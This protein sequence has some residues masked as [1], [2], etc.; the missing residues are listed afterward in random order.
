MAASSQKLIE[1]VQKKFPNPKAIKAG[2]RIKVT[3]DD[4]TKMMTDLGI[5]VPTYPAHAVSRWRDWQPRFKTSLVGSGLVVKALID[6]IDTAGTPAGG[7]PD[8]VKVKVKETTGPVIDPDY[9]HFPPETPVIEAA[10]N[11][12][13]NVYLAGPAGCGKTELAMRLCNRLSRPF[14]RVNFDG[15]FSKSDFIGDW[16]LQKDPTGGTSIMV[17]N[18]GL[19]PIAMKEGAVL[20]LDEFDAAPPE[21]LFVLQSVLEGKPLMNTRKPEKVMAK[22]GFCVIA[23]ANTVGKGDL[24]SMYSGTRLMNMATL[25]RFSYVLRMGYPPEAIERDILIRRTGIDA[26]QA[27]KITQFMN[28]ARK[29]TAD[30]SIYDTFSLRKSLNLCDSLVKDKLPMKLGFRAT[31]LDRSSDEDRVKILELASRFWTEVK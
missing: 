2:E 20:V 5:E 19:L 9:F 17:F 24:S 7:P 23:T 12:H 11:R 4:L 16:T 22:T 29:A 30:G 10:I 13:R 26:A 6:V 31:M 1:L 18:E 8:P 15:E 21:I 28:A 14:H 25:D 3:A 27:Q